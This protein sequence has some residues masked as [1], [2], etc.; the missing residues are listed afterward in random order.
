MS[1][2]IV[3]DRLSGNTGGLAGPLGLLYA[4]GESPNEFTYLP[5]SVVIKRFFGRKRKNIV[6]SNQLSPFPSSVMFA[7]ASKIVD[8]CYS[9]IQPSL[10]TN[11]F[12]Y[13][14]P[15]VGPL[16]KEEFIQYQ[17]QYNFQIAL[18]D[19]KCNQYNFEIDSYEADRV[20]LIVQ[21]QG[22]MENDLTKNNNV[23]L[24]N[25]NRRYDGPPEAV[26]VSI[27][28][29][30][31]C[32]KITSGYVLDKSL[33]NTNGLGGNEGIL[34]AIGAG[35]PFFETRSFSDL[36]DTT[37]E[38][39]RFIS[40][41]TVSKKQTDSTLPT[42]KSG[43][44]SSSMESIKIKQITKEKLSVSIKKST[45]DAILTGDI[46]QSLKNT[47]IT[48]LNPVATKS[49]LNTTKSAAKITVNPFGSFFSTKPSE[50]KSAISSSKV[51]SDDS[52]TK[53]AASSVKK[54]SAGTVSSN[55]FFS[56]G[57]ALSTPKNNQS[58]SKESV[59]AKPTSVKVTPA[60]INV[61]P[62]TGNITPTKGVLTKLPISALKSTQSL[63]TTE[64][65]VS[66]NLSQTYGTLKVIS[67]TTKKYLISKKLSAA[68]ISEID[69]SLL[70]YQSGSLAADGVYK[71]LV[72]T[73]GSKDEAYEIFPYI[74]GSLEKGDKKTILNRYYQQQAN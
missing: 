13:S 63:K 39:I 33:G 36:I 53:L 28:D 56:F 5:P 2:G 32:Y 30:G 65:D 41:P 17:R 15:L 6:N 19:L 14:N 71:Q 66:A 51:I 31:L 40:S 8:S 52:T 37:F 25:T 48:I 21:A 27:N 58:I 49:V 62:S 74:I 16:S 64:K 34:E 23:I 3:V 60:T 46:K 57:S 70:S 20:W 1:N 68:G 18:P 55:S 4:L 45:S 69:A 22:N 73:V 44:S 11:D 38:K 50:N 9:G 12:L 35:L 72:K 43:N 24:K 59:E 61:K 10:L 26:S 29:E 67:A 42:V 47:N 54:P 7:L